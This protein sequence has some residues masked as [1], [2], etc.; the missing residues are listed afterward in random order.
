[1]TTYKSNYS[2]SVTIISYLGTLLIFLFFTSLFATNSITLSTSVKIGLALITTIVTLF[3]FVN[4]LQKIDVSDDFIL[5][6]KRL[7]SK[8]INLNEIIKAE[9]V[10][11]SNIPSIFSTQGFWGFNGF[12][13]DGGITMINDRTKMIR[14]QTTT[15]TYII[16]CDRPE[17]FVLNL[18]ECLK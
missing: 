1:M 12:Q 8:K 4:S 16:S 2:K 9:R 6:K 14:I 5:L 11:S 7:F 18:N 13:M 15:E 10:T 3:L 17:E